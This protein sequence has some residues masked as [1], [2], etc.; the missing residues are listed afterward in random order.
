MQPSFIIAD[1]PPY[2]LGERERITSRRPWSTPNTLSWLRVPRYCRDTVI[3]HTYL[4]TNTHSYCRETYISYYRL[5]KHMGTLTSTLEWNIKVNKP[6]QKRAVTH[7]SEIYSP[8]HSSIIFLL[9]DIKQID[10]DFVYSNISSIINPV[11]VSQ[12]HFRY[13]KVIIYTI[14]IP[15]DLPS[16]QCCPGKQFW[17]NDHI[18]S[19]TQNHYQRSNYGMIYAFS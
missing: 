13:F 15:V 3:H 7:I 1:M 5:C 18:I 11:D 14:S 17:R 4:H 8:K 10:V 2:A 16:R 9:A 6:S 19:D 12:K